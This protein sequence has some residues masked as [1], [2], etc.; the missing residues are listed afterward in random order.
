MLIYAPFRVNWSQFTRVFLHSENITIIVFVEWSLQHQRD[1][2]DTAGPTMVPTNLLSA[3]KTNIYPPLGLPWSP[4]TNCQHSKQT[5]THRWAYHGSH[6]PIVSIHNQHTHLNS[7]TNV[8]GELSWTRQL[9]RLRSPTNRFRSYHP[10]LT[11]FT[12]TNM[13]W[14]F[15]ILYKNTPPPPPP[16]PL[17]KIWRY[18]VAWNVNK[19]LNRMFYIC[20]ENT[21][22]PKYF[23]K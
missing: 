20:W 2:S 22:P 9:G 18:N 3:F 4:Q 17:N 5:Y 12:L 14:D 10:Y 8:R 6:K 19:A 1:I 23:F 15:F 11:L 16:P 7:R 13:K 21:P